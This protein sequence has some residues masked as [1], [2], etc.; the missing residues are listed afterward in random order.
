MP[1]LSGTVLDI[2]AAP[3]SRVV[4]VFRKDSGLFVGEV[5][6]NALTGAWSITTQDTREHFAIVH[7]GTPNADWQKSAVAM[8]MDGADHST[9]F[10]DFFGN[11]VTIMGSISAICL[12]L[13]LAI[14]SCRYRRM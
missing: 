10:V 6:S 9:A 4:R 1:T 11:K 13:S 7:D 2:S 5:I 14:F 8:P 12:M 3:V